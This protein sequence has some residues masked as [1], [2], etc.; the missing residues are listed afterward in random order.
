[1]VDHMASLAHPQGLSPLNGGAAGVVAGD[2]RL[3]DG[4]WPLAT[5]LELT[6]HLEITFGRKRQHSSRGSPAGSGMRRGGSLGTSF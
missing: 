3:V 4:A 5:P 2:H 1:M 6:V